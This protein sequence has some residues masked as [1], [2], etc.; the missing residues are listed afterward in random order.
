MVGGPGEQVVERPAVDD[1]LDG[2]LALD[3]SF[4]AVALPR[5]LSGRV[6]E[7]DAREWLLVGNRETLP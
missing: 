6:G 1:R 7:G 3:R 5:E 4:A 2:H